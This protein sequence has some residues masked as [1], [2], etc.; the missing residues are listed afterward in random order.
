MNTSPAPF[1]SP[2]TRFVAPDLED[3]EAP[4]GRDRDVLRY[5]VR[6]PLGGA[7]A[8]ALGRADRWAGRGA[9]TAASRAAAGSIAG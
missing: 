7:D 9:A 2:A 8:D 3:R 4:V 1:V 6:L 5:V